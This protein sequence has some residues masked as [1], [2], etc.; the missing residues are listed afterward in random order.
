M[1]SV[2]KAIILGRLGKDP[3]TRYM[4]SGEAVTSI[5]VATSETWKD[6]AT[7]EKKEQTEWHRISFFGKLAEIAGQYLKKGSL[8]YVE[9]SLRTRKYTDKDGVEKFATDIKADKMQMVGN[10]EQTPKAQAQTPRAN[11]QTPRANPQSSARPAQGSSFTNF[12]D[13]DEDIPF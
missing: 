1:S 2:N 9:G 12:S 10:Q 13:M 11:E 7:G 6:K 4:P 3:E 8:V 5:T